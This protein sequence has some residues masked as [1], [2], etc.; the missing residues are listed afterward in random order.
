MNKTNSKIVKERVRAYLLTLWEDY[1]DEPLEAMRGQVKACALGIAHNY[2]FGV[3]TYAAAKHMMEG[4]KGACYFSEA[5]A[6]LKE[7]LDE[8]DEEAAKY[9]DQKTWDL[10]IHLCAREVASMLEK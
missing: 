4:G 1:D 8:T 9:D 10:Y 7:W 6:L 2:K 5:C 3:P